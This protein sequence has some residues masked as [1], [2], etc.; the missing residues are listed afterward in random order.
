LKKADRKKNLIGKTKTT[1]ELANV[2]E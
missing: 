1:D 2:G